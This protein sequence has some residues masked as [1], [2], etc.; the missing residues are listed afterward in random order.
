[1]TAG[2]RLAEIAALFAVAYLRLRA[3]RI[4]AEKGLASS[5]G[6]EAECGSRV[7]SPKSEDSAA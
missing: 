3:A 5:S 7:H 2:E 6:S 1:M 4:T